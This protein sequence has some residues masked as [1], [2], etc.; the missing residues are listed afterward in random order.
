MLIE[1]SCSKQGL[2]G[3]GKKGIF[4]SFVS[5]SIEKV[6]GANR[7]S[8]LPLSYLYYATC[9]KPTQLWLHRLSFHF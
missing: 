8:K 9:L 1:Q 6:K 4:F 2:G 5:Y 3:E 7:S